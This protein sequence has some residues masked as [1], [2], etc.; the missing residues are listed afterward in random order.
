MKNLTFIFIILSCLLF[1]SC[2]IP[3]VAKYNQLYS[4]TK[5]ERKLKGGFGSKNR[6]EVLVKD[7]RENEMYEEDITALKEE[8]EKYI[9]A[10]QDLSDETKNALRELKVTEGETT[11]EVRLLLGDPDKIAESDLIETWIYTINK[12]RAFTVFIIPVF[13]AHEGYYLRFQDNRLTAI[14]R[15]LPKQILRQASGPGII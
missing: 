3:S 2:S 15:H 7:F 11:E 1:S 6:T 10:H 5:E 8:V 14:E 4:F 13:V 12:V 9:V